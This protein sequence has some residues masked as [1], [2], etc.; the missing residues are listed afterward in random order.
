[1]LQLIAYPDEDRVVLLLDDITRRRQAE[2]ESLRFSR[3][4]EELTRVVRNLARAR[5]RREVYSLACQAARRLL[6][7]DG[8]SLALIEGD[9]CF[10]VAEDAIAP[11]WKGLRFPVD[12]SVAGRVI[13]EQ[14]GLLVSDIRTEAALP[15]ANFSAT[16]VRSFAMVPIGNR[17][18]TAALGSFWQRVDAPTQ[19][20]LKILQALG[21]A[22]SVALENVGFLEAI[23]EGKARARAIYDHLPHATLVWKRHKDGFLLF[24]INQ[25]ARNVAG[26]GLLSLLGHP[27]AAFSHHFSELPSDLQACFASRT[28]VRRSRVE[29]CLPGMP[30]S[31]LYDIHY[32]FIPNDMVLL[33]LEDITQRRATEEQLRSALRLEAVGRL[34]GGVAHDFNNLLSVIISYTDFAIDEIDADA[35]LRA[36]LIEVRQAARRAASLTKQLLAFSRK[37]VLEPKLICLNDVLSSV[38]GMIRRLIGSNIDFAVELDP[39]L[40]H[41][42]ADPGQLEQVIVNLCVN[43][44]DAMPNGGRLVLQSANVDLDEHYPRLGPGEESG[45]YIMLRVQ[46]SGVGIDATTKEHIFEPFFTTKAQGRGTGLGLATVYGIVTQSGGHIWL[47]SEPEQ[48]CVFEI[49][50]PRIEEAHA[51]VQESK[52]TPSQNRP[53]SANA[54]GT[55]GSLHETIL[56]VDDTDSVRRLSERILRQAGFRVL[57]ASHGEEA[58]WLCNRPGNEVDLLL[59]D[60]VMPQMSGRELAQVLREQQPDL[61]VLYMSGYTDELTLHQGTLG[62]DAPFIPKP[63]SALEL[64]KK[65]RDCLDERHVSS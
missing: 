6:D 55:S 27:P 50:L 44:R 42:L 30:Q 14:R 21:D 41:V 23:E 56:V 54:Q 8:S 15:R 40:G 48:G 34:A 47:D 45:R 19:H 61:A 52:H 62:P 12:G 11:L 10:Y 3:Q 7:S 59:T 22:T 35:P 64:T 38:E 57:S 1:V 43:A 58:I 31:R 26:Q 20:D 25:A 39:R 33:H 9:E 28:V 46:D 5:S 49:Y 32:C 29:G 37:Q 24:D 51:C 53:G 2:L 17:A 13:R 60:I 36:D 4:L 18:P 65:V 63:F 16:F